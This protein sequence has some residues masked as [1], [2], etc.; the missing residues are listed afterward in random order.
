MF[1][2]LLRYGRGGPDEPKRTGRMSAEAFACAALACCDRRFARDEM[3]SLIMLDYIARQKMM[4]GKLTFIVLNV[5]ASNSKHI[6]IAINLRML[7][8]GA[9][10]REMLALDGEQLKL[11]LQYQLD[12]AAARRAGRAVPPPPPTM[13][14]STP[15][16]M[17]KVKAATKTMI[18]SVLLLLLLLLFCCWCC[19]WCCFRFHCDCNYDC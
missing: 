10:A 7:K 13:L 9:E 5:I 1:P 14:E 19:C 6:S 11:Y 8:T 12:V 17:S 16:I 4:S 18:N 3:F 15:S 2:W